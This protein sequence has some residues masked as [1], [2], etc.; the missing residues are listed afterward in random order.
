[1]QRTTSLASSLL[2]KGSTKG[3]APELDKTDETEVR[4]VLAFSKCIHVSDPPHSCTRLASP[5]QKCGSSF[6][7]R[8]PLKGRRLQTLHLR[9]R[10]RGGTTR[11]PVHPSS[12]QAEEQRPNNLDGYPLTMV[13]VFHSAPPLI[14]LY[15]PALT[16]PRIHSQSTDF[17]LL[18]KRLFCS[19]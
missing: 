3:K 13:P 11:F 15:R 1:M 17:D 9:L 10:R 8:R 4:H 19:A 7:S 16:V 14:I 18:R 6:F 2:G 12:R 5:S